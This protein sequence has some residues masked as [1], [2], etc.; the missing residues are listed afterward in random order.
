[1]E[2]DVVVVVIQ[3]RVN[4]FGFLSLDDQIAALK[5]VQTHIDD[6]GGDPAQVTLIGHSAGG[7]S[8]H[9][10]ML[11]PHSR[12]LFHRAMSLSGSA[13]NWWAHVQDSKERAESAA[14]KLGC[15]VKDA[16]ETLE[17]LRRIPAKELF[18]SQYL[19]FDWHRNSIEREPLN[20]FSPR[21]DPEVFFL[22]I[23]L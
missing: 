17:C 22:G 7:A 15:P 6:Y 9:Y 14:S 19:S 2:E 18:K 11:S 16:E 1:M 3:Y 5:W 23:R 10:L 13:L 4:I 21:S 20:S 12:G 8:V